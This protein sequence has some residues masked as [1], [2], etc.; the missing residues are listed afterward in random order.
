MTEKIVKTNEEWQAILRA[1]QAETVA[2]EVTRHEATERAFTG[3][4]HDHYENGSYVC[5]CC[6]QPLFLS[7]TKFDAVLNQLVWAFHVRQATPV[8]LI[9]ILFIS[10][11]IQRPNLSDD[12]GN[13]TEKVS[14]PPEQRFDQYSYIQPPCPLFTCPHFVWF[15]MHF[16]HLIRTNLLCI[17]FSTQ[18][19]TSPQWLP[20]RVRRS[21]L[22]FT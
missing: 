6:D 10:F 20:L 5:I 11:A 9:P 21:R 16:L 2:Y 17:L 8:E 18:Q 22:C 1:K 13:V 7:E 12:Q 14:K 3:K 4:Y 15:C 19:P